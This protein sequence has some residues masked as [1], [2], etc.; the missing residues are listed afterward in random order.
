V[1]GH[2]GGGEDADGGVV[3]L[4][5]QLAATHL[6]AQR[7]EGYPRRVGGAVG[8]VGTAHQSAQQRAAALHRH[9]DEVDAAALVVVAH[10]AAEH[11]GFLLAGEG[12]VL[13][14]FFSVHV[15]CL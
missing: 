5:G 3:L 4:D 15:P 8:G 11:R 12:L 7:G 13:L 10:A 6:L 14:K 9:G 2:D 1:V